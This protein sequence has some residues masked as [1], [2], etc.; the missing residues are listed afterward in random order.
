MEESDVLKP[1]SRMIKTAGN[2]NAR[3][4]SQHSRATSRPQTRDA[5]STPKESAIGDK[6]QAHFNP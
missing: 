4:L 5:N 1:R 2:G 3:R 6:G